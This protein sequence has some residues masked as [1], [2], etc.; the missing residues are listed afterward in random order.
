MTVLLAALVLAPWSEPAK[1]FTIDD[2]RIDELSGL[3]ASP[4]RE[5]VFYGHNDSGDSPR[6]FRFDEQGAV[7]G[8]FELKGAA[9]VDWED[10]ASAQVGGRS[11]LYLGDVGDNARKR[12]SVT[13][14][15][16]PEPTG[17]GRALSGFETY[18]LT[19]PDHPRDCEALFV[20]AQ[21][22]DLYLVSKARE[23]KTFVYRLPSP[24]ASGAYRLELLGEIEID[25]KGMGG[26]L[27]T[28]ADVSPDGNRVLLRTY[29][30]A[31][32]Y[33]VKG[34]FKDWWARPGQAVPMPP[35]VQ[36]EA[37]CYDGDGD[38][39]YTA[40]EGS[41]TPVWATKRTATGG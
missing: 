12:P 34:A 39:V 37:V 25:T 33:T 30:G 29:S 14:Y 20:H 15:R 36:A 3:A 1:A 28:A 32:E 24:R 17:A 8:V 22:G 2:P 23:G 31:V 26:K 38:Q 13:V 41:P 16:V 5:G 18:T 35:M 4:R 11:Y 9:A 10:M 7:T 27:V 40:S 6:F 19:Y 21:S